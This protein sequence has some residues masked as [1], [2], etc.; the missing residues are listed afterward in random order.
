MQQLH[1]EL[2]DKSKILANEID[3]L[4]AKAVDENKWVLLLLCTEVV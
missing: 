1:A 2:A 3:I 4:G